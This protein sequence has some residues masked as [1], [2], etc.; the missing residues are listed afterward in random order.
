MAQPPVD[1]CEESNDEM[2]AV[3]SDESI[4]PVIDLS[5]SDMDNQEDDDGDHKMAIAGAGGE[6]CVP[7]PDSGSSPV[8]SGNFK[9]YSF[10]FFFFPFLIFECCMVDNYNYWVQGAE[11]HYLVIKGRPLCRRRSRTLP[12]LLL[13]LLQFRLPVLCRNRD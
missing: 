12:L 8:R 2:E 4:A 7:K 3:E 13:M 1:G 5:G 6:V 9:I 10:F 11:A